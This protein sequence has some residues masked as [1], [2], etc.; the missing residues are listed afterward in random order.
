MERRLQ[1]NLL[2]PEG[3]ICIRCELSWFKGGKYREQLYYLKNDLV[4]QFEGYPR[5]CR[6][7]L[8]K[9]FTF[10][11]SLTCLWTVRNLPLKDGNERDLKA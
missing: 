11:W 2:P 8:L 10:N 5:A 7:K 9:K 1:N 3:S 6:G 4:G